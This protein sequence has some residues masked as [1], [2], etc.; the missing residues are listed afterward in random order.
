MGAE[1]Y[2]YVQL[3]GV[4]SDINIT[5]LNRFGAVQDKI[6]EK[7]PIGLGSVDAPLIQLVDTNN[8]KIISWAMI[9]S[10]PEEYFTEGGSF[11]QANIPIMPNQVPRYQNLPD[12]N[13]ESNWWDQFQKPP[14]ASTSRNAKRYYQVEIKP[15]LLA[16]LGLSG[17]VN[18]LQ[19][20][21]ISGLLELIF[22]SI[23]VVGFAS[24]TTENPRLLAYYT[25]LRILAAFGE[26]IFDIATISTIRQTAIVAIML[27]FIIKYLLVFFYLKAVIRFWNAISITQNDD[28]ARPLVSQV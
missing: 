20:V 6:K 4:V 21:Y 9:N 3:N 25:W 16:F 28:E 19:V 27:V 1:R 7:F 11:L 15:L 17:L 22:L 24:V 8:Q 23:V 13:R 18:L 26:F 5:G 10:L 14:F 2:L 12:P